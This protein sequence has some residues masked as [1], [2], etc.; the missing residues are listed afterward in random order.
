MEK[1]ERG[2][3]PAIHPWH[4]G[5]P[6]APWALAPTRVATSGTCLYGTSLGCTGTLWVHILCLKGFSFGMTVINPPE[7]V[8]NQ[9]EHVSRSVERVG[10]TSA[11]TAW[12]VLGFMNVN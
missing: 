11:S 6:T 1:L 4:P 12:S 3:D 7:H 9:N 8:F 2:V 10:S 5:P